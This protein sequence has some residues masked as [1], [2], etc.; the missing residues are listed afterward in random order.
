MT[1]RF[2]SF[3]QNRT[4]VFS[5]RIPQQTLISYDQNQSLTQSNL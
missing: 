1:L 5:I 3:E 2:Q 4:P